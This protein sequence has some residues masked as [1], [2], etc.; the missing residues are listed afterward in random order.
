MYDVP[1]LTSPRIQ[2]FLNGICAE[3]STYLEVGSYLGATAVAA[4]DGNNLDAYFVDQWLD[5]IQAARED[6]DDMPSNNKD[7]FKQ[8]V[9][10]YK[11]NNK[12]NLFDSDLFDVDISDMPMIDVFFY[13][14]PH[15]HISTA[16]AVSYYSPLF[17]SG[18]I[19]IFDD[20]NFDGVISGAE[21]GIYNANI[22]IKFSRIVLTDTPENSEE[23]WNGLY[24]VIV[25]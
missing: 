23:M 13:D 24:I 4:L 12:I 17:K 3:S 16:A 2:K 11:G 15:D 1:G 6:I 14:G 7:V 8:N 22:N 19:L 20:A 21:Q 9:L 18:S 10:K 25:K 5:P